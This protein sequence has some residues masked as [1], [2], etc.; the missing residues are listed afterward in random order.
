LNTQVPISCLPFNI[1]YQS[2]KRVKL[3]RAKLAIWKRVAKA[4]E[5]SVVV[6]FASTDDIKVIVLLALL[7]AITY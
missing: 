6:V 2:N 3:N 5:E 1:L 4:Q 7:I